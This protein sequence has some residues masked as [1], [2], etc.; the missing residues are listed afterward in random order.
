MQDEFAVHG[1]VVRHRQRPLAR[2]Q[3]QHL[4]QRLTAE[5]PLALLQQRLGR[6]VEKAQ[7]VLR[8]HCQQ[9][10]AHAVGDRRGELQLLLQASVAGQHFV[11]QAA[12]L[13]YRH[14]HLGE[15]LGNHLVVLFELPL[16]FVRQLQQAEVAP[17]LVD[18]RHGQPAAHR[19]VFRGMPTESAPARVALQFSL[20]QA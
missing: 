7:A 20:A 4:D 17:V 16:V 10:L 2:L 5:I 19:R 12:V 11:E 9:A 3:R 14:G 1:L 18:Q 13:Q 6:R 8:I 15:L